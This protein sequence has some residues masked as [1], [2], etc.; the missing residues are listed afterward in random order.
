[1]DQVRSELGFDSR[2]AN[3]E[4]LQEAGEP[5]EHSRHMAFSHRYDPHS[6]SNADPSSLPAI[7]SAT[8]QSNPQ[9]SPRS[10]LS[11]ME[12]MC[13]V[14]SDTARMYQMLSQ[15]INVAHQR[16]NEALQQRL[17]VKSILNPHNFP[18]YYEK[19]YTRIQEIGTRRPRGGSRAKHFVSSRGPTPD[20]ANEKKAGASLPPAKPDQLAKAH[21]G[22]QSKIKIEGA[23]LALMS[24][25]K[26][27]Q[28]EPVLEAGK[29][30]TNQS[31]LS[32]FHTFSAQET[33]RNHEQAQTRS[34]L[35]HGK[36][37]G[38]RSSG[39]QSVSYSYGA[40]SRASS[41]KKADGP[42]TAVP[43][44]ARLSQQEWTSE[45]IREEIRNDLS[46]G[47][48]SLYRVKI[49]HHEQA[50]RIVAPF[51]EYA[52]NPPK[53]F[54]DAQVP[55]ENGESADSP[56]PRQS[57]NTAKAASVVGNSEAYSGTGATNRGLQ[58]M[59]SSPFNALPN[60]I[61]EHITPAQAQDMLA[62]A[63]TGRMIHSIHQNA[64]LMAQ[65]MLH[66][67]VG[68]TRSLEASR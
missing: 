50:F 58:L 31:I 16:R 17:A 32:N 4:L 40:R 38:K 20:G 9:R 24:K 13:G 43:R 61:H 42:A 6:A 27:D 11:R 48:D 23:D 29:K 55:E 25:R 3:A 59:G 37:K 35:S 44:E 19:D 5:S 15:P 33:S 10:R 68:N 28:Q 22:E 67:A 7:Q 63:N 18:K 54:T 45:E 62:N 39:P 34:I 12:D 41:N 53:K 30:Q 66:D 2:K 60:F 36:K 56:R 52:L 65:G 47:M 21:A 57:L 14:G 49:K 64:Q 1:M 51:V 26:Q 46:L 8:K